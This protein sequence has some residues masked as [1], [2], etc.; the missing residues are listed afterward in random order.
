MQPRT[1]FPRGNF[2]LKVNFILLFSFIIQVESAP[3]VIA[4]FYHISLFTLLKN[5][6]KVLR[7]IFRTVKIYKIFSI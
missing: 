1:Y 4:N 2:S 6:A 3:I 5:H 7:Y